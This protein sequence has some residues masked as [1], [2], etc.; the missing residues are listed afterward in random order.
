MKTINTAKLEKELAEL[1][2]PY[3][4]RSPGYP[5][6]RMTG[7]GDKTKQGLAASILRIIHEAEDE[8]L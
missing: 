2:W 3:L 6:R 5:D 7:W 8:A 1:L 4:K